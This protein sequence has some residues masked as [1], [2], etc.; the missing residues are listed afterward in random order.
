MSILESLASCYERLAANG[1]APAYG[2]SRERIS[3]A[4]VLA[5]D[6]GVVDIA[7]LQDAAGDRRRAALLAVPRPVKRT[8]GV[9]P[10]FLWDKTAY[11]LGMTRDDS[12]R[13]VLARRGEQLAFMRFHQHLLSATDDSGLRA[14][15][16]F[17]K[18]WRPEAFIEQPHAGVIAGVN[19]AFRLEGERT[20]IHERP[21]ARAAW[22]Q[23]LAARPGVWG[24]CL[25]TGERAP[26]ARLHPSIKGVG[27]AQLSGAALVSFNLDAVTSFGR[28]RG[29][30]APVSER[31]AFAYASA[32]NALLAPGSKR[33][34]R[35][36]DATVVFWA[37]AAGN[38]REARAAEEVFLLLAGHP[39]TDAEQAAA[40]AAKL[41]M[42]QAGR[43]LQEVREDARDHTRFHVLALAPNASRLAVRC[44]HRG[45]IGEIG[46]RIREHWSD[47]R[48]EPLPVP[49]PPAAWRLL[50][51]TAAQRNP[52]NIPPSLAGALLRAILTGD[53][54]PRSL[55]AAVVMR[56]RADGTVSDLRAALLKACLRRAERLSNSDS[57]EDGLV[58]LDRASDDVAYNLGRLF[59]AYVYAEKSYTT[60]AAA[61]RDMR[62][63]AAAASPRRV[64]P[65][66]MRG[67]EYNRISLARGN[68]RQR[69]FGVRAERM[70]AEIL[71]RLPDQKEWPSFL[72]LDNQARFFVGYYHQERALYTRSD[73]GRERAGDSG[74][75]R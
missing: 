45:A 2:Y 29:A 8:F 26:I 49:A 68:R 28:D 59:A 17:L 13:P 50:H 5:A 65:V 48:L 73:A 74:G 31:A 6:G 3:Y 53:R 72:P 75:Q 71:D 4:V 46:R 11:A 33:S 55:L 61:A 38:E 19:V 20:F 69:A 44:W 12:G 9:A 24:R 30:N 70:V 52:K 47:L 1:A 16:L 35:I 64:F 18:S 23:H 15:L 43:P 21:A 27:G 14:L 22:E 66:L 40:V 56:L 58:S 39:P 62:L 10:N 25:I 67:H 7:P 36:A 32:L 57:V 37:E 60:R 51:E 54:Y 42:L 63:G 41:R 34:L